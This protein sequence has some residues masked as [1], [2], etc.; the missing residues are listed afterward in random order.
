MRTPKLQLAA[1]QPLTGECWIPPKNTPNIQEQRRS[2]SRT[3]GGAKS[4][5]ESNPIPIRDAQSAQTKPCTHQESPQRLSQI[6]LWV[7]ECLLQ[8]Y[9]STVACHKGRGSGYRRQEVTI[10]PTIEPPELT[11]DWENRLLEGTNKTLHAPGSRRKEQR[12]HKRLIPTCPWMSRSLQW[13]R[14]SVVAC[15]RVGGTESGS[16]RTGPFKG[17]R[18]FL[19]YLQHSLVSGQ[20]TGRE[21]SPAHRQKIGL[22]IYWAWPRPWEQDLVSPS[23]S[24]SHQEASISL[25]SEKTTITEN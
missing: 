8:R 19:Y 5:L 4:C 18:P 17:G 15:C 11:L 3:V 24:L 22:Q 23:V 6:C 25:L 2:P 13:R 9:G 12:P 14:G 21:H 10:N 7:S 16:A 20:T 1:E